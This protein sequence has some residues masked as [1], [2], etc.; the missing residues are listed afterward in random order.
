[1]QNQ[2]QLVIPLF[3]RIWLSLAM[4]SSNAWE[5]A[6]LVDDWSGFLWVHIYQKVHYLPR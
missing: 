1:M 2:D 5:L 3:S 4:Q 6:R